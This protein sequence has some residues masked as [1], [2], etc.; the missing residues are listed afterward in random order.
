MTE[1]IPILA[2]S[3]HVAIEQPFLRST[4]Q[5]MVLKTSHIC[6]WLEVAASFYTTLTVQELLL[7]KSKTIVVTDNVQ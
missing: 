6:Q 5:N 2:T 4:G 1:L 3:P 7:G